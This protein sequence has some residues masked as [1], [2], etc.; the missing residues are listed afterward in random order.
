MVAIARRPTRPN[1]VA[2][3]Q[4]FLWAGCRPHVDETTKFCVQL[5]TNPLRGGCLLRCSMVATVFRGDRRHRPYLTRFAY[6]GRDFPRDGG[7]RPHDDRNDA[8]R[9]GQRKTTQTPHPSAR[10]G[11]GIPIQRLSIFNYAYGAMVSVGHGA[12]DVTGEKLDYV[13]YW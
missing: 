3:W 11:S 12:A 10:D 7:Y 8:K 13:G 4:H 5:D 6:H 1:F 9:S 2:N